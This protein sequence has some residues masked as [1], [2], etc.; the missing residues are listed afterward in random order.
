LNVTHAAVSQHVRSLESALGLSLITRDGQ[1]MVPTPDGAALASSLT[2]GFTAI[3]SGVRDLIDRDR[4]RPLRIATTPSFAANWLMPRIGGFWAK[5]PEIEIALLPGEGLTD[6]RRDGIDVAIRY[7]KGG[8][9]GVESRPILS[10]GHV[11]VATPDYIGGAKV[12]CLA[13]MHGKTW[14]V[15]TSPSEEVLWANANGVD[16]AQEKTIVFDTYDLVRGGARAGL[17]IAIM[18]EPVAADD[19]AAGRL[20]L[21]CREEKSDIAYHVLTRPEIV[22]ARRDAFVRWLVKEAGA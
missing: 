19:I 11:A 16:L 10:A 20:V 7:G 12:T 4:K 5:H 17:G 3:A 22:S 1:R 8:W 21:L 6:L 9:P 15:D 14:L 2:E 18:P 13:D